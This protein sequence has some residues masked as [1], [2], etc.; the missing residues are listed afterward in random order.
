MLD[1]Q[2]SG[3]IFRHW[4]LIDS[5]TGEDVGDRLPRD[6]AP[7]HL[8]YDLSKPPPDMGPGTEWQ[9]AP[10]EFHDVTTRYQQIVLA[11]EA[12]GASVARL[13]GQGVNQNTAVGTA[14]VMADSAR[15]EF[16]EWI[17]AIEAATSERWVDFSRWY[18][19]HH[20]DPIIV[21]DVQR[22]I[23]SEEGGSFLNVATTITAADV[24]SENIEVTLDTRGRIQKVADF[25]FAVEK[26]SNGMSD[27]DREV[28]QGNIP[29]VDDAESEKLAIFIAEAERIEAQVELMAI[30]QQAM[31]AAGLGSQGQ[32][33]SQ[34]RFLDGT[35]TDPRG[36]GTG[37][38]P[39]NISDTALA[40]GASDTLRSA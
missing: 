6:A 36:T 8:R 14:D 26:I 40:E 3:A 10:F 30:Q 27:F 35:R 7:E 5:N 28:E 2:A 16:S 13:I 38:G 11:H 32:P 23:E 31:Q 21:H 24:V 15:D 29:G 25:R 34:P 4:Q 37:A 18:R 9:L 19:N 20:K 33:Q 17:E 39:D 1:I 22:D 12:A